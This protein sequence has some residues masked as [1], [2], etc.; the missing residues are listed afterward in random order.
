[1]LLLLSSYNSARRRMTNRPTI[2]TRVISRMPSAIIA[3]GARRYDDARRVVG[4]RR[5]EMMNNVRFR[6]V[7]LAKIIIIII[8]TSHVKSFAVRSSTFFFPF[9]FFLMSE[10]LS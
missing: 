5:L 8:S 1:M 3:I 2:I 7:S 4:T 9:F 6:Q 10:L